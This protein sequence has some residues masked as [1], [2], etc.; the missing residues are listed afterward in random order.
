[1]TNNERDLLVALAERALKG[2][3]WDDHA[4]WWLGVCLSAV[5]REIAEAAVTAEAVVST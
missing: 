1:M 2:D 4:Q 5:K 3:Q